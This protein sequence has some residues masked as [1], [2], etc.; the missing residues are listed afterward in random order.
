MRAGRSAEADRRRR[1]HALGDAPEVD[2]AGRRDIPREGRVPPQK[3][4][5]VIDLLVDSRAPVDRVVS[6]D[7]LWRRRC[8]QGFLLGAFS[9]ARGAAVSE[10]NDNLS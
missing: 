9:D 8:G 5:L 6:L 2:Q 3:I 10:P 7:Y 1:R 4:Y